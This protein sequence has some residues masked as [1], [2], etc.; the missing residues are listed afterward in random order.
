MSERSLSN[1]VMRAEVGIAT[2]RPMMGG[3]DKDWLVERLKQCTCSGD[4]CLLGCMP[5][6]EVGHELVKDVHYV[7]RFV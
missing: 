2:M 6:R 4:A 7:K 3:L 1:L 5:C